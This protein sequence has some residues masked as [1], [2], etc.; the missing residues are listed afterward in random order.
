MQLAS[1]QTLLSQNFWK[2]VTLWLPAVLIA[3]LVIV[4]LPLHYLFAKIY[5]LQTSKAIAYIIQ[6]LFRITLAVFFAGK[7]GLLRYVNFHPLQIARPFYLLI[8][9]V[10]PGVIIAPSLLSTHYSDFLSSSI[11]I[12][13]LAYFFMALSEEVLIR[14]LVLSAFVKKFKEGNVI[15]AVLLS[16]LVF[17][18]MHLINLFKYNYVIVLTQLIIA[19]Y[20]GV[21]FGA[22]MIKTGNVLYLGLIHGLINIFFNVDEVLGR[23][24]AKKYVEGWLEIVKS[25]ITTALVLSPLLIIGLI[26]LRKHRKKLSL[27]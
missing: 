21:F 23:T 13:C 2:S 12:T 1:K 14:G 15:K 5:S 10:F 6:S 27:A 8:P 3:D 11:L 9:F 26:I 25:I 17:S 20:F 22:L 4:S 24:T 18:L 19:F 16:A 7:L